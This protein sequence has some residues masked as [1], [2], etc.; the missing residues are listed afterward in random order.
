MKCKPVAQQPQHSLLHHCTCQSNNAQIRLFSILFHHLVLHRSDRISAARH[1]GQALFVPVI[2]SSHSPLSECDIQGHKSNSTYLS[3]MEL[4]RM[5]L[6]LTLF[7]GAMDPSLVRKR[8]GRR[9]PR[10]MRF[11]LGGVSCNWRREIKPYV[12]Y[13]MWSRVLSWDDNWLYIVT[14]FVRKGAIKPKGY[15]SQKTFLGRKN[16]TSEKE[17]H[18]SSDEL[19]F[20]TAPEVVRK[21]AIYASAISKYVFKD[22][23]KTVPAPEALDSLGLLPELQ[24]EFEA[25]GDCSR[26]DY[27]ASVDSRWN[28]EQV[29]RERERGLEMAKLFAGLDGLQDHFSG[30]SAPSI[31][32]FGILGDFEHF[33]W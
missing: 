29:Q 28:H 15:L 3:D 17:G 7:K 24:P 6:L 8:P 30:P 20:A 18:D 16:A 25:A 14:H 12:A 5:H 23:Q 10:K 19:S 1:G 4:N 26:A 11:V 31:G 2:S 13:E 21:N 27:M 22:G 9:S 32:R 33:L